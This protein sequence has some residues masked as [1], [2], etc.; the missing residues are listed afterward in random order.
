MQSQYCVVLLCYLV[1][2]Q[3]LPYM[4]GKFKSENRQSVFCLL[5]KLFCFEITTQYDIL[6]C[7]IIIDTE[8][9]PLTN[10]HQYSYQE[11]GI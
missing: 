1:H 8:K 2:C 11:A 4:K 3:P 6:T 10:L 7:S 9:V 5:P